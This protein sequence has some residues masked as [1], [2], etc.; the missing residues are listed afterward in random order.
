GDFE[1][2][3]GAVDAGDVGAARGEMEGESALVAKNVEGVAMGVLGGG[4]V[5]LALIEEGSGLLAFERVELELDAV[6]GEDCGTLF[7]GEQAG[8]VR[9][10]FLELANSRIHALDN[11]RGMQLLGQLRKQ[12][13]AHDLCVHSLSDN[14]HGENVVVAVDDK[15]GQE[16]GFAEDDAVSVGVANDRLAVGDG[17]DDALA[18]K[19]REISDRIM[20][21][22][23]DG[24][25]RGA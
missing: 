14:L 21:N 20:R 16:I 3:A 25:L 10:E 4:G 19:S 6:H 24:D 13:G 12:S 5:V 2:G 8:R 9:R 17:F 11:R 18:K 15:A 23:A 1:R 7:T 22:Q